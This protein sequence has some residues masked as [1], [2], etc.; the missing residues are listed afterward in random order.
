M[1]NFNTSKVFISYSWTSESYKQYVVDIA[2]SLRANGVETLFDVWDL[3]PG[4]DKYTFMEKI[5]N[6]PTVSKVLILCDKKYKEKADARNGGVGDETMIITPEIYGHVSQNKFIPVVMERDSNGADYLPAYLK[7]RMY[8][9]LTKKDGFTELLRAIFEIPQ[10]PKP[11]IGNQPAFV[12]AGKKPK[13]YK[14]AVCGKPIEYDGLLV[15]LQKPRGILLHAVSVHKGECDDKLVEFGK[16]EGI[17]TNASMEMSF[18]DNDEDRE[19]YMNGEFAMSDSEFYIKF[20]NADG[21]IKKS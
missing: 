18:F 10:Y 13:V 15:K 2:N 4:E 11:P 17:N 19:A 20:F 1:Q 6:D 3:F 14:C 8:V 7:S 21:T 9:D 16:R 5:I 12:T